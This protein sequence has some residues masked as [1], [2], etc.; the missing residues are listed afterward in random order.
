MS[1]KD[2]NYKFIIKMKNTK[3]NIWNTFIITIICIAELILTWLFYL[4]NYQKLIFKRLNKF[5]KIL[6]FRS[7]GRLPALTYAFLSNK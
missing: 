1:S 2:K 5:Y 3:I 6:K 7:K 4:I